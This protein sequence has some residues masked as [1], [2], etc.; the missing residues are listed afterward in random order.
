MR[1]TQY[2]DF[3]FRVL[4][5]LGLHGRELS[6]IQ[7]ISDA[8]G[9]SR[10]H[11]MKVVQQLAREGY[12]ES[13]RGQGGGL[14]LHRD[15]ADIRLGQLIRD[16]EPDLALVE[17]FR[18]DNECVITP[19]CQLPALL[20]QALRAFVGELDEYTLADLLPSSA[21]SNLTRLLGIEE[22]VT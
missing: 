1:L 20:N 15:P 11:L 8:Y 22:P 19:V 9:I 14:R 5:Y 18:C 13:I 21:S 4:I 2:S 17:C 6:T 3:S 16:M 7:E 10:N 12:V